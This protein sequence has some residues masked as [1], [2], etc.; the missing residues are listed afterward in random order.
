MS[1]IKVKCRNQ[2]M[3]LLLNVKSLQ[4]AQTMRKS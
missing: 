1:Q 3:A 4:N 2:N